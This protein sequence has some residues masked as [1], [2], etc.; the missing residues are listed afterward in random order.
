M[1]ISN[2]GYIYISYTLTY[3]FSRVISEILVWK[4]TYD[5]GRKWYLQYQEDFVAVVCFAFETTSILFIILID[6]L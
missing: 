5:P 3:C 2:V 4:P 1:Q 6:F